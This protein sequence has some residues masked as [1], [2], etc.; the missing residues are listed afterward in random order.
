MT[1]VLLAL[2]QQVVIPE[3][4]AII[5]AHYNATGKFPTEAEIFKALGVEADGV[6]GIGTA[7]L[8]AH[9]EAK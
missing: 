9:P 6:I 1:A 4:A 8:A 2:I 7:W 3:V 5:R